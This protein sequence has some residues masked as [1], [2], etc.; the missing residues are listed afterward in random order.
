M[1][2]YRK[3]IISAKIYCMYPITHMYSIYASYV[4]QQACK[5]FHEGL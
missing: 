2:V 4:V 3:F 5:L 1:Y